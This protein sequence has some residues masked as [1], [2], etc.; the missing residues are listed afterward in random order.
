MSK[1]PKVP[2]PKAV[3][4]AES[5]P[6]KEH[7]LPLLRKWRRARKISQDRLAEQ[8]GR[9]QPMISAWEK[10]KSDIPMGTVRDIARVL[11]VTLTQL[12]EHDPRPGDEI[13]EVWERIPEGSHRM[14][15]RVLKGMTEPTD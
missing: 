4:A 10:G 14:A 2:P 6:P 8:I 1:R 9:T 13:Y 3:E 11:N 5:E 15:I 7:P 12:L